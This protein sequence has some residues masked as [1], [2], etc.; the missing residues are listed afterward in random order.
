MQI[1][2]EQFHFN[3]VRIAILYIMWEDWK[4]IKLNG[5]KKKKKEKKKEGKDNRT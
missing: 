1:K 3:E 5:K 4:N 2:F